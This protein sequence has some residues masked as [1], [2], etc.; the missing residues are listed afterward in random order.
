[1]RK[2]VI[3]QSLAEHLQ[4]RLREG[5]LI[6][7]AAL[8][9]FLGIAL[10]SYNVGDPSWSHTG[11]HQQIYNA[12]GAIGAWFA[13]IGLSLFGYFAYALPMI[14]LYLSWVFYLR[15]W[16][17][18]APIKPWVSMKVFG[19]MLLL[20]GVTGFFSLTVQQPFTSLPTSAGG[21]IGDLIQHPLNN[22]IGEIGTAILFVALML[23]GITLLTGFSWLLLIQSSVKM[24]L[25]SCKLFVISCARLLC[26]MVMMLFIGVEKSLAYRRNR[27]LQQGSEAMTL[28]YDERNRFDPILPSP[29]QNLDYQTD[30]VLFDNFAMEQMQPEDEYMLDEFESA[31]PEYAEQA[32]VHPAAL[33]AAKPKRRRQPIK[34]MPHLEL[35]D[36]PILERKNLLSQSLLQ[37]MAEIVEIKLSDFGVQAQVVAVHPGPVITRFELQLA[38]GVKV[39]K[40]SNL[41]KDLARSLSVISVRIVEVIPG[42]T[43]VGLEVPNEHREIVRL[44]EVLAS[45]Q[46]AQANSPLSLGLGKDIAGVPVI[47]DICKMPHLLVAGTTGSGKS[48]CLNA[49]LLSL[50][51][52]STPE[53]VRLIM[54]DPKML[55]LA[56]YDGIPHLLAPVVTDMK[57]AA[58]ALRWCVAEMDKRYQLMAA[59]GVRNIAGYNDKVKTAAEYGEAIINPII[60]VPPTEPPVY[61]EPL[62]YI[63]VLVDEFADMMMVVGKK[64]EELI[65]R[66]AQKARAAGIHLILATQ[67]PS[68][69]VITG[70]IKANIP[71]RIA[72]QVSSKID[73]RT[74]IDQPG[75]EQLLGH[76]DM[77]Y[78]PPGAGLPI[79]VHGA[80]VADQ[81]VHSVVG[82]LKAQGEPDY[83]QEI[84][85]EGSGPQFIPGVDSPREMMEADPEL[86]PLYD[87][88]V[89]VVTESRRASISL[90][91]RRLKIGYNRAARLLEAM[92]LAGVVSMMETNGTR[93][94]LAPPP[95]CED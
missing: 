34:T 63:V 62:P 79:R 23:S 71:S 52:K 33:P 48:V 58:N 36:D 44:R 12:G 75:A 93:E 66:I 24:M 28:A 39:S 70:L 16:H 18:E 76:G 43:V 68:V 91:Q 87:Q 69:D 57:E 89:R 45:K 95:I 60:K 10:I 78:L 51:Y 56:V 9:L 26:R 46:Y 38:A 84:L 61:L 11:T 77:L 64:V 65:A 29:M 90:V 25:I 81:E 50:L 80:Y 19:S 30:E 3:E 72:F 27:K 67:R 49:I 92:E 41:A 73:S 6:L 15:G 14:I 32:I 31:L 74:V 4:Y 1:M 17:I 8:A 47:V 40:I 7:L 37:E 54:I 22:Q 55:E 59:L 85:N 42:K 2:S 20:I 86:D 21:I 35:L 5:L 88:A 94:V 53:Q 13:D 82:H 83:L